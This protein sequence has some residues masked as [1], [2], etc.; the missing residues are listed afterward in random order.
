[1]AEGNVCQPGQVGAKTILSPTDVALR[2]GGNILG[3]CVN[4]LGGGG[5]G[6]H[7][8]LGVILIIQFSIVYKTANILTAMF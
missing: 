1:M 2:H 4:I 8:S 7:H 3:G 5:R 6:Y